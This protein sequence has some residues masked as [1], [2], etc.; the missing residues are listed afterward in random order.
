MATLHHPP[1]NRLH[2][3]PPPKPPS[4]RRLKSTNAVPALYLR[5]RTLSD[6][7]IGS[8]WHGRSHCSEIGLDDTRED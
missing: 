4:E 3:F 1:W 6:R 5:K 2:F 8:E 7:M